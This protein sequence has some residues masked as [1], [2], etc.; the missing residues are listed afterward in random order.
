MLPSETQVRTL[1]CE[2]PYPQAVVEANAAPGASATAAM[3]VTAVTDRPTAPR[4]IRLLIRPV[5]IQ[6]S[7]VFVAASNTTS[8]Q[9]GGGQTM[10]RVTVGDDPGPAGPAGPHVRRSG[11]S[12]GRAICSPGRAGRD[13][14]TTRE[15]VP[16]VVRAQEI[17]GQ[18]ARG[19]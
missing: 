13:H 15:A 11:R 19:P 2:D 16:H 10:L 4:A 14:G 5:L 3:A 12:D 9:G 7:S 8:D 6:A 1:P 17:E 18:A